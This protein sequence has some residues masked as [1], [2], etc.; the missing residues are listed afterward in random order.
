M[1]FKAIS[2]TGSLVSCYVSMDSKGSSERLAMQN[3]RILIQW[4]TF[5]IQQWL[6]PMTITKTKA[7]LPPVVQIL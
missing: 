2:K 3:I 4:K 7:S 5:T 6:F 1:I